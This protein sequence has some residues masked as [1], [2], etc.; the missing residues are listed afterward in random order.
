MSSFLIDALRKGLILQPTLAWSSPK[1]SCLSLPWAS[2]TIV[3]HNICLVIELLKND[4]S[5]LQWN[6]SND[7]TLIDQTWNSVSKNTLQLS[8]IH[9]FF[10]LLFFSSL[11]WNNCSLTLGQNCPVFFFLNENTFFLLC[12]L[13]LIKNISYLPWIFMYSH[14]PF[15]L[16]S[17][18]SFNYISWL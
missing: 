5:L 17:S 10:I 16:I 1:S 7:Q 3:S 8:Y 13:F 6:S 15:T 9:S 2:S 14:F 18:R 4:K 12:I 11:F